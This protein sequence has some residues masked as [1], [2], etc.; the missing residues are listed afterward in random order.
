MFGKGF[1]L[2]LFYSFVNGLM[3]KVG[4][5]AVFFSYYVDSVRR[6]SLRWPHDKAKDR[7]W[8]STKVISSVHVLSN[9]FFELWAILRVQKSQPVGSSERNRF[10]LE[11]VSQHD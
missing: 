2:S 6:I 3:Q 4:K 10:P 9:T 7:H 5:E 11:P 1:S 8:W